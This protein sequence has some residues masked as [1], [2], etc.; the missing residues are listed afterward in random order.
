MTGKMF[1]ACAALLMMG[2]TVC[3]AQTPPQTV[4]GTIDW[5]VAALPSIQATEGNPQ[6]VETVLG[7][8]V[9]F[10]G[11]QDAWFL[12]T[13]P[14][15]GMKEA[16]IEV[17]FK[18]DGDG[19]FAQ[20]FLHMGLLRGER[21]MFET[22]VNPDRTW[23]FD[24][25]TSLSDGN[26]LT[27]IDSALHHPTD[28]WYNVTLIVYRNMLVTYVNGSPQRWGN[29]TFLPIDEGITSVGVRQNK[30]CWFKG[31]MYRIRITP[32]ALLPRDL[33]KDYE[34]LNKAL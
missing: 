1:A 15:K 17:I 32:K 31:Q 7:P 5:K 26:K 29:L 9:Q 16:T 27:L 12:D 20:R 33:L 34:E 8:A 2:T 11:K 24:A 30:V 21:I 14:L 23:Y 25:H 13:N 28:R 3:R 6:I 18:P 4:P 10:D 19:D 22:R